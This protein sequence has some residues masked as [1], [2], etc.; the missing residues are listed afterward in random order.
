MRR[1]T[2]GN[3]IAFAIALAA[4]SLGPG[5]RLSAQH[6]MASM[7]SHPPPMTTALGIPM[8]RSGS[9]TSWMPDSSGLRAVMLARGSWMF[10]LQ[11][12]VNALYIDQRTK[13]GDRQV[14]VTDWEMLMAMR[15]V[16]GGTLRVNAMTSMEPFTLGGSGY[17]LLLQTGGT[18]R[19]SPLHDRQHP[20]SALMELTA[21]YERAFA[22]DAAW[23]VY[24]GAVGEP[25][26]GPVSYMHRPSAGDD[27]LAP[28]AHHWQDANHESFGVVT[29]GV[30]TRTLRV[31][32]SAFNPRESDEHHPVADYRGARL[33][34]YAGRVS[35]APLPSVVASSW[36]GYL[37][38]HERL[39]PT[40]RMHRYGASLLTSS[41][42]IR[43]GRLSS[44]VVWSMNLHH[45]GAT[46]HAILHGG[47]GAS[48]HHHSSSMLAEAKLGIGTRASLFARGERVMKNGEELG[49]L[50]GDLTALYDVRTLTAGASRQLTNIGPL[51]LS[52]GARGSL[53]FVPASLLATYGTRR[54][55]GFAVYGTLRPVSTRAVHGE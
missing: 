54:P 11:G 17:P 30:N 41:R 43:G 25:A 5:T 49:F 7:R 16:R 23:F 19:H 2:R 28:L 1:R 52:L 6:D 24:T 55:A 36:W 8:S 22:R 12:A 32:G 45:H 37:D 10:M 39:D 51:G 4:A 13:R 53:N 46:S 14:G 34:S 44:T 27:P 42:G 21:M 47:P 50:G 35:W 38:S 33:D 18:Y 40:A 48:P 31:E 3:P 26:L 15:S 29:A 20:H 9:G